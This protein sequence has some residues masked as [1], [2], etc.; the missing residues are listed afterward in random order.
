MTALAGGYAR[1]GRHADGI[2]LLE[3][4]LEIQKAKAGPNDPG[5]LSIMTGL[6]GMH[7]TY[8]DLLRG[9]D[10][11]A[12]ARREYHEALKVKP[13]DAGAHARLL[14]PRI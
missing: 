3:Q 4:A 1:A 5:T 12:E 11:F 10:K 8:G 2:K 9:E 7:V 6:A 14:L 13:D